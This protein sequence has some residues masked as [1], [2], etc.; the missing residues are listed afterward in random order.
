MSDQARSCALPASLHFLDAMPRVWWI[1]STPTSSNAGPRIVLR[2][3]EP[4]H[5]SPHFPCC[6]NALLIRS[7]F[8]AQGRRQAALPS[9]AEGANELQTQWNGQDTKRWA[10]DCVGGWRLGGTTTTTKPQSL[11]ERATAANPAWSERVKIAREG[12]CPL[13]LPLLPGTNLH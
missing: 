1:G 10:G 7:E 12:N 3:I 5:A 4:S 11:S 9:R 2:P 6:L 8:A 13:A